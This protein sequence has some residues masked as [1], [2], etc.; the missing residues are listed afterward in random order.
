MK[1]PDV[2]A[3]FTDMFTSLGNTF[4]SIILFNQEYVSLGRQAQKKGETLVWNICGVTF[5]LKLRVHRR[6]L[7]TTKSTPNQLEKKKRNLH[8][9]T[10]ISLSEHSKKTT[11][12]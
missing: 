5:P 12:L 1:V 11:K 10:H 8:A 2:S 9:S 6:S 7:P 3:Q 4:I